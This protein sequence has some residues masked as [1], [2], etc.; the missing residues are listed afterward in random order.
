M[1]KHA[2]PARTQEVLSHE[3]ISQD[4][5]TKQLGHRSR[6]LKVTDFELMR[7]LGTGTW[8]GDLVLE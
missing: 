4:P 6:Y 7:T 5:D 3:E 8:I 1:L 2:D